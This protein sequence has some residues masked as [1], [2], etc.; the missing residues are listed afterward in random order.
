MTSLS[1]KSAEMAALD[2]T[3]F[4][5]YLRFIRPAAE[6]LQWR[7]IPWQSDLREA[8]RIAKEQGKPIFL[9]T[10]NGNPLGCT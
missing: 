9:W 5:D 2:G 7:E 3:N 10:M 4:R 6:E 1:S 8:V